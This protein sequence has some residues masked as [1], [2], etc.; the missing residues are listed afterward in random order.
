MLRGERDEGASPEE[1]EHDTW[2]EVIDE[3][4]KYGKWKE[5]VS[6]IHIGENDFA[7][8]DWEEGI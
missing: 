4:L 6:I 3:F 2:D 7:D 1:Y 8:D 5:V